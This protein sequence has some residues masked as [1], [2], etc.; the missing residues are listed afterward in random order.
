MTF[1]ITLI[2]LVIE[3]FFHWKQLRQ[4]RWFSQYQRKLS[5]SRISNWP[6]VLLLIITVL[7]FVLLVG[8]L[9]WLLDNWFY[10]IFRLIL[11]I[12]VLTYCL[13]PEN[14]W[15]QVYSCMKQDDPTAAL[16][17]ADTA[18]AIGQ[19]EN[20]RAF[21][22][23]L[24]RAIFIAANNRVFAV[25]F[26]FILLGPVG[27]VLYRS[28]ALIRKD[29][30]LGLE[31]LATKILCLLD[32][33]PVRLFTFLFALM[34]HFTD[35]IRYWKQYIFKGPEANDVLLTGCGIASLSLEDSAAFP[36]DGSAEKAALQL[37]D[38]SFVAGL[39]LLAIIV[40]F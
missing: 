6:S 22:Q 25:T 40:L 26:W 4:W 30:P 18:F 8:I 9:N 21:H 1:I 34:G 3:R 31:P 33:I 2:S 39:V 15:M 24:T 20:P 38:R 29:S 35:V 36:E 13:G 14:L 10:G 37:L 23:A 27:A 7:P 16:N 12:A 19:P 17:S 32:W 5:H 28:I 11:G